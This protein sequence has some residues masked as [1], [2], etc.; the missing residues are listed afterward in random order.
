LD[1]LPGAG[2]WGG[3]LHAEALVRAVGS[4]VG[5]LADTG[6]V[7]GRAVEA[8][9]VPGA[10]AL[11]PEARAGEL[12]VGAVDAGVTGTLAVTVSALAADTLPVAKAAQVL[13]FFTVVAV[14]TLITILEVGAHPIT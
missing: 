3:I 13:A 14:D 6:T 7:A 10:H 2:Q 4:I 9:A 1:L 5:G 11:A 12:A 8:I